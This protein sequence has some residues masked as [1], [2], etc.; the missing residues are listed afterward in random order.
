MKLYDAVWAPSPR[1]V[2]IYL[3]EKGIAVERVM[4]DLRADEQL[5]PAY[6]AVNPRGMVPALL[7]DDGEV[8]CESAAICRYFEALHPDPPLFGGNALEIARIESMTRRIENEG[9]AAAV[10]VLRNGNP[11]FAGRGAAGNWPNMA[12]IPQLAAR[13]MLM[14]D[15]FVD[16]LDKELAA[17]PW[18]TGETYTFA[19]ITALATIDFAKAAKLVVPESAANLRRWHAAASARPSAAA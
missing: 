13:G 17:R 1:R 4:I 8:I 18:M 14:W 9:Y 5:G 12:Q 7:L 15:M 6:L 10:Y 16:M 11:A 2:R 19:D 3:A